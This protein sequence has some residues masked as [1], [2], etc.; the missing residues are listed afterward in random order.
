MSFP[1][2]EKYKES[3][4]EWLGLVPN[5]WKVLPLKYTAELVTEK[6]NQREFPVALENIKGWSGRFIPGTAEYEGEGIG[7]STGDILFGKLRPYLAKVWI[8][9][10]SGEAVGDFHVLRTK[11]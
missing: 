5:E 2:Y 3:G 6:S 9:S 10:R 8:A 11:R 7:F 1:R 4:V